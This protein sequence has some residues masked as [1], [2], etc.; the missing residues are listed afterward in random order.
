M[1]PD[2]HRHALWLVISNCTKNEYPSGLNDAPSCIEWLFLAGMQ[3]IVFLCRCGSGSTSSCTRG[4][5]S[6]ADSYWL[7]TTLVIQA[8]VSCPIGQT[9][10]Q[11]L[12]L[13]N[14][15]RRDWA[16][17]KRLC[18]RQFMFIYFEFILLMDSEQWISVVWLCLGTR[19]GRGPNLRFSELY[20]LMMYYA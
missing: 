12:R 4:V 17:W 18:A 3:K 20:A 13:L 11:R 14:V 6:A 1:L 2:A 7:I 16:I 9:Q 15:K 10:I 8:P 19:G 5:I